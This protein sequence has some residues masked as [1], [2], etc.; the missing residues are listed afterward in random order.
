VQRHGV[1][2]WYGS[3]VG[4]PYD[5]PEPSILG[6]VLLDGLPSD[7]VLPDPDVLPLEGAPPIPVPAEPPVP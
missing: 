4:Q 2:G 1:P 5:P 3:E 6:A 7:G